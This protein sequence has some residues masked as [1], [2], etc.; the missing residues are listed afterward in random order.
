MQFQGFAQEGALPHNYS[1]SRSVV[2]SKLESSR[3]YGPW[4]G[5]PMELSMRSR[6]ELTEVTAQEYRGAA[7]TAK[8]RILQ[9]FCHSNMSFFRDLIQATRSGKVMKD[10][11]VA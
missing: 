6:K 3:E 9:Q 4:G 11:Q 7:R 5:P 2:A 1:S 8:G 10:K